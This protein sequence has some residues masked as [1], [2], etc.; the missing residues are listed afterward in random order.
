MYRLSL[1]IFVLALQ[2]L[3]SPTWGH[4]GRTDSKGG[5]S[6]HLGGYHFHHGFGPHLHPNGICPFATAQV[7]ED[8]SGVEASSP[9]EGG[10][11]NR[12]E[13][14]YVIATMVLTVGFL[15]I[16]RDQRIQF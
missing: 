13:T 10:E 14:F 6:S 3:L 1:V 7:E 15:A 11:R 12:N 2:G 8:H 9:S 16:L 4:S 5:H